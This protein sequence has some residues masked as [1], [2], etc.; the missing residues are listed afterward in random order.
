MVVGVVVQEE[1]EEAGPQHKEEC[2]IQD[3]VADHLGPEVALQV[4]WDVE[5]CA[6]PEGSLR[7]VH[8]DLADVRDVLKEV[9]PRAPVGPVASRII[10][11]MDLPVVGV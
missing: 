9:L 7:N 11:V 1:R 6:D 5:G 2:E 10:G 8:H 4:E 3:P